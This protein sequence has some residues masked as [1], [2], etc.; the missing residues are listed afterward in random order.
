MKIAVARE[1]VERVLGTGFV[2]RRHH[3]RLAGAIA[4]VAVRKLNKFQYDPI[5]LEKIAVE[6]SWDGL[7]IDIDFFPNTDYHGNNAAVSRAIE[8]IVDIFENPDDHPNL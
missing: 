3:H 7:W 2:K 6:V 8:D 5:D 1:K 4:S